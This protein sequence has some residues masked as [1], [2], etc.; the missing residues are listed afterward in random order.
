MNFNLKDL[1]DANLMSATSPSST[2]QAILNSSTFTILNK[3]WDSSIALSTFASSFLLVIFI[4][5]TM[6]LLKN[7]YKH[8]NDKNPF[9]RPAISI[10]CVLAALTIGWIIEMFGRNDNSMQITY[11]SISISPIMGRWIFECIIHYDF[12]LSKGLIYICGMHI[13]GTVIGLY[14]SRFIVKV[15]SENYPKLGYT[16]HNTFLYTPLKTKTHLLKSFVTWFFVGA[17]VPFCGYFVYLKSGTGASYF[18]PFSATMC[19]LV[20][21]F[22]LMF[23]THELGYYDGNLVLAVAIQILN[24]FSLKNKDSKQIKKNIPVSILFAIGSPILWGAIY[25]LLF[26]LNI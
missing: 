9:V 8:I 3:W 14:I 15:I 17:T 18:T 7:H 22:I 2:H 21:I 26:N 25:G 13:L 16:V 19:A 12:V 23:F 4:C 24:I 20:I 11:F 6:Y 5:I 1:V 10:L